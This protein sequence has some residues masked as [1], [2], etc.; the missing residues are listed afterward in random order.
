MNHYGN[1]DIV[2]LFTELLWLDLCTALPRSLTP[3]DNA[4]HF[5]VLVSSSI[6]ALDVMPLDAPI[7]HISPKMQKSVGWCA[8]LNNVM[9][10]PETE[11]SFANSSEMDTSQTEWD[12]DDST[13]FSDM[14]GNSDGND[15]ELNITDDFVAC[16]YNTDSKNDIHSSSNTVCGL[17]PV[18][19]EE[20]TAF[21]VSE[22]FD[23]YGSNQFK[24]YEPEPKKSRLCKIESEMYEGFVEYICKPKRVTFGEDKVK[25][26]DK[27]EVI[28]KELYRER[29]RSKRNKVKILCG[30]GKV[31][32]TE[33]TAFNVS[34]DCEM[35]DS[36]HLK[37]YES[38]PEKTKIENETF[39]R[40]VEYICK[41][42][43]VTFGKDTVKY[44][45]KREVIDKELC[46]E[47]KRSRRNNAKKQMGRKLAQVKTAL[48]RSFCGLGQRLRK[49]FTRS[50]DYVLESIFY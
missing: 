11:N 36:N 3:S 28:D 46:V 45:D 22:R 15:N 38:E 24:D 20:C 35:Y 44:F 12:L 29:K 49:F 26:F 9:D 13:D 41:P 19:Y 39:D 10:N 8:G 7:K 31:Y 43:R 47:R 42:T 40:F 14:E 23:M 17:G 21:N 33:C 6:Q 34:E 2:P 18:Y 16:F 37:D 32:E 1:Q 48:S 5:E 27:R 50:E 30:L 25:Y 4:Q